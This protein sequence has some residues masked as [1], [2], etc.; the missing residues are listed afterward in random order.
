MTNRCRTL[1]N[2]FKLLN[3][4]LLPPDDDGDVV[5][6]LEDPDL[7]PANFPL[8]VVAALQGDQLVVLAVENV[9]IALHATADGTE[10]AVDLPRRATDDVV[11]GVPCRV[12]GVA[13]EPFEQ[14]HWDAVHESQVCGWVRHVLIMIIQEMKHLK[15][16]LYS[17]AYQDFLISCII[18]DIPKLFIL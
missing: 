10:I 2:V 13:K 18:S 12:M 1:P 11:E 17:L 4:S 3:K 5:F 7:G 15:I 9:D 6:S 14:E 8:D 16:K